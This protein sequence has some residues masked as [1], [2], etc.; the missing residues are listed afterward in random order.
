MTY[1]YYLEL[2][3]LKAN[4][5]ESSLFDDYTEAVLSGRP[6]PIT[7]TLTSQHIAARNALWHLIATVDEYPYQLSSELFRSTPA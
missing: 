2:L 6:A 3:C 4:A 7:A 5:M 1:R